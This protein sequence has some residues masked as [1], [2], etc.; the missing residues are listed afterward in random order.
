VL[1]SQ[2]RRIDV[3]DRSAS[4]PGAA[5]EYRPERAA[6]ASIVDGS[7][8]LLTLEE[9]AVTAGVSVRTLA[10]YRASG[11][12]HVTRIGRRVYCTLD[13]VRAALVRPPADTLADELADP[14][15]TCSVAEWFRRAARLAEAHPAFQSPDRLEAWASLADAALPSLRADI[16]TIAQLRAA[17]LRAAPAGSDAA[18]DLATILLHFPDGTT[19]PEAFRRLRAMFRW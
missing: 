17:G 11:H 10:R 18:P 9:A 16:C 4:D 1:T 19:L 3:H 5:P 14:P 13:A 12:L 8:E 2:P 15:R 6:P 7:G